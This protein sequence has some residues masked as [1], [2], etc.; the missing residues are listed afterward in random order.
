MRERRW[1]RAGRVGGDDVGGGKC[2]RVSEGGLSERVRDWLE[3]GERVNKWRSTREAEES[4]HSSNTGEQNPLCSIAITPQ[5]FFCNP[6]EQ[7][8]AN[9]GLKR[10]WQGSK[11]VE[12]VLANE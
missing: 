4:V 6:A 7:F 3:R 11:D 1:K 12:A 10:V 8:L 2:E 9:L 5:G